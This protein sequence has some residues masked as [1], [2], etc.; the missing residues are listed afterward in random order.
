MYVEFSFYYFWIGLVSAIINTLGLVAIANA[1]R[2]GPGGPVS[3][4]SSISNILLVV[5]ECIKTHEIPTILQWVGLILGIVGSLI[6]VIP[7]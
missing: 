5:I 2:S 4:V 3:A 1:F 7:D 6:L